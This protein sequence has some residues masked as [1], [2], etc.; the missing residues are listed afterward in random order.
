MKMKTVTIAN[1]LNQN[2]NELEVW[3]LTVPGYKVSNLGNIKSLGRIVQG[4]SKYPRTIKEKIL[5]PSLSIHGYLFVMFSFPGIQQKPDYIH[6]LVARM[7]V[8]N[9]RQKLFVNHKNGIKHDNRAVNLEWVTAAENSQHAV[10][11]GLMK[12]T[13]GE[14]NGASKLTAKDV[15]FIRKYKDTKYSQTE[16][17]KMFKVS[18]SLISKIMKGDLWK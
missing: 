8:P 14:L 12:S 5:K 18:T 7:F 1:T 2:Q 6:I 16:L 9:P 10:L 11:N 13:K 15:E 17:S 4:T 3:K